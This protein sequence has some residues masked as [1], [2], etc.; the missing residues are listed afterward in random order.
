MI[1]ALGPA[2]AVTLGS[3]WP[4]AV[5]RVIATEQAS[6][7]PSGLTPPGQA[8]G[9]GSAATSGLT[10]SAGMAPR[11]PAER[12]P[13]ALATPAPG[14]GPT[15]TGHAPMISD[16]YYAAAAQARVA[17]NP[18][19]PG[20]SI[21]PLSSA[22]QAYAPQPP[23]GPMSPGQ[24]GQ[25]PGWAAPGAPN[26]PYQGR[27]P[28]SPWPQ[29]PGSGASWPG[30]G[31]PG[32]PGGAD[33]LAQ[34]RLGQRNPIGTEIPQA[35]HAAIR[36]LYIGFAATIV[37]LISSTL[38]LGRYTHDAQDAKDRFRLAAE[39]HETQMA[40]AMTVAVVADLLGLA[41]WV[42]IAIACR[43]GRGWTR[44]AGTVLL[45]VYT[46]VTLLVVLGT[47]NDPGAR[48]M[49][50]LVWALGLAAVI[51]LWTQQARAFFDTWRRR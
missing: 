31:A 34:Y 9:F 40:G 48:F 42:V 28:S 26:A 6:E 20:S 16:G 7:T 47:H 22:Q 1:A 32:D 15:A 41:C 4:E 17:P 29:Q 45:G 36:L 5:A 50:V 11:P 39:S 14:Q 23:S 38:V 21:P 35:V 3:F 43:R 46:V 30:A 10:G 18:A 44:I 33:A 24:A 2:T 37:A 25:A 51:P 13:T 49:T 27:S 8:A 19:A 12:T